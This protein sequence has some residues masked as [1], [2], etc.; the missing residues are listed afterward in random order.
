MKSLLIYWI[1][2]CV[3]MGIGVGGHLQKCPNDKITGTDF[4]A[5]VA[6]WPGVI[7]AGLIV[8]MKVDKECTNPTTEP[9]P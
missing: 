2:G 9:H 3:A 5:A 4:V 7:I 8:G 6:T 1:I